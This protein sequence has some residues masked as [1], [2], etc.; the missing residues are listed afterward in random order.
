MKTLTALLLCAPLTSG[1]VP[2]NDPPALPEDLEVQLA[3]SALPEHLRDEATVYVYR[4]GSGYEVVQHGSNGFHALVGRDDP[5]IRH[6]TWPFDEY[7]E[8]ILIPIAFDAAGTDHLQTYLDLGRW[9]ATGVPASEAKRRLQE[10]FRSGRYGAPPRSGVSYMLAP[11]LRAYRSTERDESIGTFMTPHYMFYAPGVTGRDIGS[12]PTLR[13]PVML[14]ETP[15]PHGV[16]VLLAGEKEREQTR[17]EN[18]E[19]L[20][21]LCALHTAWCLPAS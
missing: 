13:H 9:R 19:M 16:I 14:N 8:D 3:R 18:E 20:E 6:G 11:L 12:G 17:Q 4:S 2:L 10:G 21:R 15:D 7:A 1:G 5:A